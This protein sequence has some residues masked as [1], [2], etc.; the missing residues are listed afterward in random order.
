MTY[1]CFFLVIFILYLG[2]QMLRLISVTC[3]VNTG[4]ANLW[5]KAS[6]RYI[7]EK[8]ISQEEKICSFCHSCDPC[9]L[10]YHCCHTCNP[11]FS[12]M[13]LSS[14]WLFFFPE[15]VK[16]SILFMQHFLCL[17]Y[18]GNLF[19]TSQYG[20]LVDDLCFRKELTKDFFKVH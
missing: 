1:Y 10:H 18:L 14:S 11:E 20:I 7:S 5:Y 4:V 2:Q 9:D 17:I 13:L 6:K 15:K 19:N 3:L 8:T 16:S 12:P